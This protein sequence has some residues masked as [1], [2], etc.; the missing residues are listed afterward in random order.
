MAPELVEESG[1]SV[2]RGTPLDPGF[3]WEAMLLFYLPAALIAV[4]RSRCKEICTGNAH[5]FARQC[6]N[7]MSFSYY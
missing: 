3:R 4:R 6:T 1:S 7:N 2:A 5:D